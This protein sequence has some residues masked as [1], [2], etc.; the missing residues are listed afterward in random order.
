MAILYHCFIV[1]VVSLLIGIT[2]SLPDGNID[3]IPGSKVVLISDVHG[4]AEALMRSLWLALHR[5]DQHSKLSYSKFRKALKLATK[6]ESFPSH[7]LST[8]PPG[9]VSLVQLGD[10]VDRGPDSVQ[11]LRILRVVGK[12][13][14]WRV[15]QLYGNHE[16]IRIRG[17]SMKFLHDSETNEFVRKESPFLLGRKWHRRLVESSLGMARLVR[18]GDSGELLNSPNT[19]FVHAGI[20]MRWLAELELDTHDIDYINSAFAVLA[21]DRKG[22]ELL[23]E[24]E[25]PLWTSF[26]GTSDESLDL[27]CGERLDIVLRKFKVA[28]IVVGHSPQSDRRVKERCGGRIILTDVQMSRWMHDPIHPEDN[29]RGATPVAVIMTMGAR[30]DLESI[31]AHYTDLAT[32]EKNSAVT[33]VSAVDAMPASVAKGTAATALLELAGSSL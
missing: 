28:R 32:G 25:S 30:G 27:V 29:L 12:V 3:A 14:G 1:S 2:H 24:R 22:L 17:K 19:L 9:S 6:G 16:V 31:V 23:N 15:I 5:V 8:S 33:I 26:M 13:L 11:C 4:D 18:R 21:D 10:V 20:D 7:P